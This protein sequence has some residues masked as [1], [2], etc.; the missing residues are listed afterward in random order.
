MDG[1]V[2]RHQGGSAEDPVIEIAQ[3]PGAGESIGR[4]E[5]TKGNTFITRTDGTKIKAAT[6]VEI[7]QGDTVETDA[8]GSIGIVFAD[9]T[10]FS[11]AEDGEMVIDE[12]VYDP[13][14]EEGSALFQV[15]SGVFT[16]ASGQIAKTGVDN[17]QITTPTATIGI[18]GTSGAVRI[19]TDG[20]DTYTL[21]SDAQAR[22]EAGI[23][24]QAADDVLL[25]QVPGAPPFGGMTIGNNVGVQILNQINQTT[26][27][28]TPF[29]SPTLPII[30][31]DFA[32]SQT[33]GSAQAILPP[34][35]FV[36][37]APTGGAPGGGPAPGQAEQQTEAGATAQPGAADPGAELVG[38]ADSVAAAG[39]AF[40]AVLAG[41]GTLEDAMGAAADAAAQTT[42]Q[43]ALS[44]DPNVFGTAGS[45]DSSM[46]GIIGDAL[47]DVGFDAGDPLDPGTGDGGAV[48][49][50]RDDFADVVADITEDVIKGSV[51][52]GKQAITGIIADI[53]SDGLGSPDIL[54]AFPAAADNLGQTNFA[55]DLENDLADPLAGTLDAVTDQLGSIEDALGGGSVTEAANF[56]EDQAQLGALGG[57]FSGDFDELFGDNIVLV[58][59]DFFDFDPTEVD[60]FTILDDGTTPS[61]NPTV[62]T[63]LTSS[64]NAYDF[65]NDQN[66]VL[67][68]GETGG[69]FN[70]TLGDQAQSGDIL[71]GGTANDIVNF[72]SSSENLNHTFTIE[73]VEEITLPDVGFDPDTSQPRTFT[74]NIRSDGAT[75]INLSNTGTDIINGA[76]EDGITSLDQN[77][78]FLDN[79]DGD[80]NFVSL[81][82]GAG[83]DSV[84]FSTTGTDIA[85]MSEIEFFSISTGNVILGTFVSGTTFSVGAGGRLSLGSTPAD[86]SF[87]TANSVTIGQGGGHSSSVGWTS[88][89]G[90]TG[91]DAVTILAD[92]FSTS[93]SNTNGGD[94]TGDSLT[95]NGSD[96]EARA[97]NVVNF[98]TL[99]GTTSGSGTTRV[100]LGAGGQTLTASGTFDT[101]AGGSGD[102]IVNLGSS[103]TNEFSTVSNA[104]GSLA[105]IDSGGTDSIAIGTTGT[106][107]S[108][109]GTIETITGGGN[110]DVLNLTRDSTFDNVLGSVSAIETINGTS[111]D[112][113]ITLSA[114][115]TNFT[116]DLG[117][118]NDSVTLANG[119]N[120]GITLTSVETVTGGNTT[121]DAVTL[122][123]SS[124]N[125]TTLTAVETVTGGTNVDNLTIAGTQDTSLSGGGGADSLTLNSSGTHTVSYNTT[126]EGGDTITGFDP[127]SGSDVFNFAALFPL[128]NGV[129]DATLQQ[130]TGT[131]DTVGATTIFIA[132]G[133]SAFDGTNGSSAGDVASAIDA[134]NTT[135]LDDGE[136]ILVIA[137]DG[138]N[139]Y[140]WHFAEDSEAG[141]ENDGD[142]TLIATV[143]N[144]ADAASF[145]DGDFTKEGGLG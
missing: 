8:D 3:A 85:A 120:S 50:S 110:T 93:V 117:G 109:S 80:S 29:S 12:M 70:I 139:S 137:D 1:G 65:V 103:G 113:S 26:Q 23:Q 132:L 21:L 134:L 136:K 78:R 114:T 24:G 48:Q 79:A 66:D 121:D 25:A 9:N 82:G 81:N 122:G 102:D 86:D 116:A 130:A 42:I 94:G 115:T 133:G 106:T 7:F 58:P 107:L 89:V 67:F 59:E 141:A 129:T 61:E 11:L 131:G 54:G 84:V 10:T 39:N 100:S 68:S 111:N 101:F 15:A 76:A 96:A 63:T 62:L 38:A 74:L 55:A 142:L 126:S 125:T 49:D 41:G 37:P 143:N 83:D 16:F 35:V 123:N 53:V 71:T 19:G 95:L 112:D 34:P 20:P 104:G 56:F 51:E 57:T 99:T 36:A 72:A 14:T 5:A 87:L 46:G 28:A 127:G 30:L 135:N 91:D 145:D 105:F 13:G 108:L 45:I 47:G 92:D 75:T 44:V 90:G 118:G 88:L 32:V 64:N 6:G 98:E 77:W 124:P 97:L 2:V 60:D 52:K 22:S 43:N 18:R 128:N 138:T 140:L 31:P 27:V 73:D 69:D 4:V 119:T 144:I 17:M 40:E 33:F